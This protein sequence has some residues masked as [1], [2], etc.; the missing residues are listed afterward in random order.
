MTIQEL[1]ADATKY[2]DTLEIPVGDQKIP[3]GTLRAYQKE[4]EGRVKEKEEGLSKQQQELMGLSEK[5]STLYS[6]LEQERGKLAEE[7]KKVTARVEPG[8]DIDNDVFWKPVAK[9]LK[10]MEETQ[11]KIEDNQKALG[12]AM[13]RSA[14]IWAEERWTNQYDSAKERLAKS[15]STKDAGWDY[16]K[17]KKYATENKIVDRWGLPSVGG[18]IE[19]LTEADRLAESAEEAFQRGLKEGQMRARL[20]SS[21]RPTSSGGGDL[22]PADAGPKLDPSKNFED[23]GDAVAQDA[24]LMEMLAQIQGLPA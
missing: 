12:T 4:I 14:E 13:S 18:A 5:A 2:P 24:E 20:A 6:Q 11:K 8:E 10:A 9:R 19:K 1:I 22:K 15:K 21:P 17:L 3:L 7:M 16:E 23:L